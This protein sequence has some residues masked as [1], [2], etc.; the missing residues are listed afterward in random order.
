MAVPAS[1]PAQTQA[2]FP[3]HESAAY[4]RSVSSATDVFSRKQLEQVPTSVSEDCSA[5]VKFDVGSRTFAFVLAGE[6]KLPDW[7]RPVFASLASRWGVERGWDGYRALPTNT[8]L[9]AQ[10]LTCLREAMPHGAKSPVITPLHDGGVQAEWHQGDRA[11][12]IVVSA[13]APPSFSYCT[14]DD[15]L[16][17]DGEFFESVD[18]IRSLITSF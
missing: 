2:F 9:V 1:L 5:I 15:A 10:L 17:Q 11:L 7:A 3:R 6:P 13:T 8:D 14:E 16:D 4:V 18:S 12:E